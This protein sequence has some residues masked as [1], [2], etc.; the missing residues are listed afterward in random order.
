MNFLSKQKD[1]E[2]G[3]PGKGI[4]GP[5]VLT[6]PPS[7]TILVKTLAKIHLLCRLNGP[8]LTSG[9]LQITW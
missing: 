6:H 1:S 2:A 9:S 8:V 5:F 7:Q 4:G 3:W